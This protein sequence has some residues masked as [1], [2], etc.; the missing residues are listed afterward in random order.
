MTITYSDVS[1]TVYSLVWP[2]TKAL[3]QECFLRQGEQMV[4]RHDA[5]HHKMQDQYGPD[6]AHAWWQ[7]AGISLESEQ[8]WPHFYPSHGASEAIREIINELMHTKGMLIV[9][10][11]EYEGYQAIAQG[12]GVPVAVLK[13]DNWKE[14][15]EALVPLLTHPS[16]FWVSNPSA[17]DGNF[18]DDFELWSKECQHHLVELW[19]DLTYI[20]ATP[21][22]EHRLLPTVHPKYVA[23]VVFSLSKPA[24]M[25]YRRVG[26]CFSR[27]TLPGMYGNMW[28]KNID[29]LYLGQ[30]FM[31]HIPRGSLP[32]KYQSH[33]HHTVELFNRFATHWSLRHNRPKSF[34]EASQVVLLAHAPIRPAY[35]HAQDDPNRFQR[36]SSF[37][38]CLTP[39]LHKLIVEGERL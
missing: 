35:E 22:C 12:H 33:Q 13:R 20:G 21:S 5:P 11:G 36:G 38:V 4:A 8:I 2:E 18:W 3:M 7:W 27:R 6:F 9:F 19:V 26:G 16:Q 34:W 14:E 24:G 25:Y 37:R 17:I 32:D 1:K 15:W 23:G 10:E 30:A 29:S 28:F 31:E 39:A